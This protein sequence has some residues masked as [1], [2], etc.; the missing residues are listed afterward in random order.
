[1]QSS[2]ESSELPLI[3]KKANV[4]PIFKKGNHSDP[5]NYRPISLTSTSC[6]LLETIIRDSI[7]EHLEQYSL[8]GDSQHGFRPGRSCNT[9]LLEVISDWDD[10]E[11]LGLPVDVIYL[12]YRKAFDSVPFERLLSKL[13]AYGIR[14]KVKDWIRNFLYGRTQEVV[15]E[16][17]KSKTAPVTSGI[18]QGSVLGPFCSS[19]M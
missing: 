2:F 11:E 9:Q 13:E 16:G 14:G 5:N 8:L 3:W 4:V 10:A 17:K 6:K 15:I 12:D 7:I 1:M 19:Y 18:P